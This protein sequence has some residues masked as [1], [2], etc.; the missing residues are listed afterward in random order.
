VLTII[1]HHHH[2]HQEQ[3]HHCRYDQCPWVQHTCVNDLPNVV[4]RQWDSL[5]SKSKAT[6]PVLTVQVYHSL[7]SPHWSILLQLFLVLVPTTLLYKPTF[8]ILHTTILGSITVVQTS[9]AQ[10]FKRHLKTF[11]F[12]SFQHIQRHWGFL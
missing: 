3:Q 2:H 12:S 11:F 1:I 5:K 7:V 4:K 6:H 10:T 8:L 9:N